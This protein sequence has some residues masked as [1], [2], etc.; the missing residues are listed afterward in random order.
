MNFKPLYAFSILIFL[1]F[2]SCDNE[3]LDGDF[4]VV[5][6][7][8]L[9]PFFKAEFEDFTFI[10][11]V[12][13]AKTVDNITTVNGLKNNGDVI[14]LTMNGAGVGSYNMVTEGEAVYDINSNPVSFSTQ[15]QGGSGQVII[16]QYDT[17]LLLISGT[18]SF[19]ATR[20]LLNNEGLPILD[21]SG[22]PTFEE[23]TVSS[24][25]FNNISIDLD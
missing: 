1:V 22:N 18:F 8:I 12:A 10:A 20:P 25:E 2:T 17:T 13:T 5:D 6:P 21:A 19:I 11:Q 24:G 4:F 16:T 14:V 3:P 7:N 23:Q 15:N 9:T